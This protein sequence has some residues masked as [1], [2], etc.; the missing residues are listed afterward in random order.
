MKPTKT[1]QTRTSLYLHKQTVKNLTIR[2]GVRAGNGVNTRGYTSITCNP[3][4]ECITV[5]CPQ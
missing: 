2:T 3:T 5:G 1:K 4:S